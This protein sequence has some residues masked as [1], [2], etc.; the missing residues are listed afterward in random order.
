[1]VKYLKDGLTYLRE[2]LDYKYIKQEQALLDLGFD[3]NMADDSKNISAKFASADAEI[4]GQL[5][6]IKKHFIDPIMTEIGTLK[7]DFEDVGQYLWA[8][9]ATGRNRRLREKTADNMNGPVENGSGLTDDEAAAMLAEF[10]RR[11]LTSK[12]EKVAKKVYA[13]NKHMNNLRVEAQLVPKQVIDELYPFEPYYV[14]IRGKSINGDMTDAEDPTYVALYKSGQSN[15]N[16]L[17]L[18]Y[19]KGRRSSAEYLDE[20]GNPT[21]EAASIPFHPIINLYEDAAR[22][23]VNAAKNQAGLAVVKNLRDPKNILNQFANYYTFSRPAR[24][25]YGQPKS[26]EG[27]NYLLVKENGNPVYVEFREDTDA[28]KALRESFANMDARD[29]NGFVKGLNAVTSGLKSVMLKYNPLYYPVAFLRDTSDALTTAKI[30]EK[31][32]NSLVY[33]KPY[34]KA[35]EKYLMPGSGTMQAVADYISGRETP[36]ALK[37]EIEEMILA[38]GAVG[39]KF[40]LN[41][42]AATEYSL[43]EIQRIARK[44]SGGDLAGNVADGFS[45][46]SAAADATMEFVDLYARFASYRA[47]KEVGLNP[48]KAARMSLDSTLDLTRRGTASPWVDALWFFTS[49]TIQGARKFKQLMSSGQGALIMGQVVAMGS[50]MSLY[51]VMLGFG[52][53]DED[54]RNDYYD[55]PDVTRQTKIIIGVPGSK[56]YLQIPMGFMVTL[57]FFIGGKLTEVAHGKITGDDAAGSIA[58]AMFDVLSGATAAFSPIKPNVEDSDTFFASL[59]PTPARPIADVSV[60]RNFFGSQI[61]QEPYNNFKAKSQLGR[62]TT[63]EPWKVIA[64]T[65]NNMSGGQGDVKGKIDYQPELYRYIFEAYAGAPY[66][67]PRNAY[68]AAFDGVAKERGISAVPGANVVVGNAANYAAMNKF[69]KNT[70]SMT[71]IVP[72]Y[73]DPERYDEFLGYAKR[74]PVQTDPEV[75]QAYIAIDSISDKL[76]RERLELL[77]STDDQ[78]ER[79]EII[80]YYRE[81]KNDLYKAFNKIYADAYNRQN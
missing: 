74:Y 5:A 43:K 32:R 58:A 6:F 4:S 48:E 78:K 60:N 7:L 38:G 76:N 20:N 71:A 42:T 62:E 28:G 65:I 9:A 68:E 3:P 17:E 15:M 81:K 13:W 45:A 10:D 21:G 8:K 80:K 56:D 52:D 64:E 51:N 41:K 27:G 1:L 67:I 47:A 26:M 39:S 46:V 55:I 14:P 79:V 73:K 70:K 49:P 33:G 35:V 11:G 72:A 30:K 19:T 22:T 18:R 12:L 25:D 59:W 40:Y 61:Y 77:E 69:F 24:D 54:G 63:E 23:V 66:R 34:H 31:D 37:A 2:K 75:L 53:D 57:P 44:T 16:K 50:M 29:V 36:T